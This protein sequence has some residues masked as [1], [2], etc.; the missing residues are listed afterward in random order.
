MHYRSLTPYR[1]PQDQLRIPSGGGKLMPPVEHANANVSRQESFTMS[2]RFDIPL[3][4]VRGTIY[5]LTLPT[6][7]DG[8][9]W[10]DQIAA[11][12]FA[13]PT[14]PSGLPQS[15]FMCPGWI[16]I[17]DMRTGRSLTNASPEVR[18]LP[19]LFLESRIRFEDQFYAPEDIFVPSTFRTVGT[20]IQPFCFTRNGGIVMRFTLDANVLNNIAYE[21]TVAFSGWK[22]YAYASE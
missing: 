12:G 8:D 10:V 5:D 22:E 21:V 15:N 4:A 11:T 14:I 7:Q 2:G 17:A 1:W 20:L 16:S 3:N 18:G 6:Q 13:C 9:F 19:S